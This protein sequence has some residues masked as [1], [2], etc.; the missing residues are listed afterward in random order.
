MIDPAHDRILE[1]NA[2]ACRMLGYSHAELLATAVSAIHP[3]EMPQLLEFTRSVLDEG[4]AWTDE[5]TC[6]TKAGD[7]LPA[8]IS[9][10]AIEIEGRRCVLAM[11]RIIAAR[12]RA[13]N[14]L[15]ESEERAALEMQ[16][17][18]DLAARVPRS[19][20]PKQ[21]RH[22]LIHVVV[23][24]IPIQQVGG[25]YCQ[26]RFA[27]S[28]TCY[29]TMCDVTGHGI[30]A[31]ALASRVSGEVRHHILNSRAPAEIVRS[32]NAFILEYFNDTYL[33]LTFVAARIDVEARMLTYCG[34]GHPSP[35]LIRG[36]SA[37][38]ETLASQNRMIGVFEDALGGEPEHSIQLE[39][40]DRLLIYTD[41]V[42][43]TAAASGRQLGT[44]GLARIGADAMTLELFEMADHILGRVDSYRE[45][46]VTDD[47]T[48][49]VAE[50]R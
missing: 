32:L 6:L 29:I 41:G 31:S 45:G 12:Q 36:G 9:A 19:L 14:A 20:L 8:E 40:G 28:T 23:R 50:I 22:D 24:Y 42:T 4:S 49:I 26:V 25:D 1:A 43:E 21:V 2:T 17:E 44:E 5:L 18:L 11:A 33:Y 34:A 37:A 15:R 13:E 46:S 38:V 39:R 48:L 7:K 35:L 10:S 30:G 3:D 16:R 27:D 47:K